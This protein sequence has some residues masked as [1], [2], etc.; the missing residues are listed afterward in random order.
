FYYPHSFELSHQNQGNFWN[1]TEEPYFCEYGNQH[2]NCINNWDSNRE[3]VIDSCPYDQ[4]YSPVEWPASPVCQPFSCEKGQL[5]GDVNGD[6]TI[7]E[8]DAKSVEQIL[9]ELIE[10]PS[11]ICCADVSGDG[12]LNV[13][14]VIKIQR[15]AASLDESPGSCPLSKPKPKCTKLQILQ[16][17]CIDDDSP[18]ALN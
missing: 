3:N 6:G 17:T 4:Y 16:G 11:D 7:T 15:I 1:R 5:I 14:D 18:P 10:G 2:L 9:A 12:I 8:K 13:G